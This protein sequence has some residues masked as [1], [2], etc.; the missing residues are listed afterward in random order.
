MTLQLESVGSSMPA[1]V[2]MLLQET[3]AATASPVSPYPIFQEMSGGH[4]KAAISTDRDT[5]TRDTAAV[6]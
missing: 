6:M 3:P 4:H 1:N 2:T 5:I